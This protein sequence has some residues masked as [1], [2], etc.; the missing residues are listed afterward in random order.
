MVTSEHG[1]GIKLRTVSVAAV[2]PWY[3]SVFRAMRPCLKISDT[4]HLGRSWRDATH[5]IESSPRTA[6]GVETVLVDR[7]TNGTD[8]TGMHTW[9]DCSTFLR[10]RSAS[11]TILLLYPKPA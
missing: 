4:S 5:G 7:L 11:C 9:I 1:M 8:E 6:T 3:R 2:V 10:H